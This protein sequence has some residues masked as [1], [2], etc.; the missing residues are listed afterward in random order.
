MSGKIQRLCRLIFILLVFLAATFE[1]AAGQTRVSIGVTEP[2]ETSNPYGDSSGLLYGI[3]SEIT[4]PFCIY[5]YEKGEFEGRLAERW[6]AE[7][8]T[9]WIFYLNKSYKFSDGTPVTAADV[10]HSMMNR[11]INDPQSK[12]KASV[13]GPI[14]KAEAVDNYTVKFTTD[15][16][17]APLLDFVATG[18]SLR[19]NRFS[20]N[21][22]ERLP[23]RSI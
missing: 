22:A 19:A 7:N 11:V 16:P 17:V 2:F 6:K 4:G 12:Q 23:I 3:W 20:T 13:A 21:M 9:T 15:Q 18:S 8:P 14:I 1:R 10:V 5:N